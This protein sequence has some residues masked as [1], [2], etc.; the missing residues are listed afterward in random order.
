MKSNVRNESMQSRGRRVLAMLRHVLHGTLTAI[1]FT[2]TTPDIA[3]GQMCTQ[4]I[5]ANQADSLALVALY[6]ATNGD[7]WKPF[8]VGVAWKTGPV[9]S[10]GG[11]SGLGQ[12]CRV[13]FLSLTRLNLNGVLP[14]ELGNLPEA[15]FIGISDNSGMNGDLHGPIPTTFGNLKKLE[16]LSLGR[17]NLS[18]EIPATLGDLPNLISLHLA[19]NQLTGSIPPELGKLSNLEILQ[20]SSNKLSGL[21][22]GELGKLGKLRDLVLAS[23][24]LSGVI[25]VDLGNLTKPRIS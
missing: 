22:P 9:V 5:P 23:N 14:A 6:D 10:W 2:I 11:I 17:N 1:F 8:T 20:L 12:D 16:V 13:R 25:P 24:Q 3:E 7:M 15:T 4:G 18:G 21:I 19:T